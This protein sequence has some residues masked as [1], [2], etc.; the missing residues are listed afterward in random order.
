MRRQCA[1]IGKYYIY[2]LL[3]FAY[4][5][6]ERLNVTEIEIIRLYPHEHMTVSQIADKLDIDLSWAS[7][8][9]SHLEEIGFLTTMKKSKELYV[10]LTGSSLG[11]TLSILLVEEP[12]MN[13]NTLLGGSSLQI[14]P[15]LLSPGYSTREIVERTGLSSRTIQNRIKKWRGMGVVILKKPHYELSQRHPLVIDLMEE[16]AK[17]RNLCHLRD[18]YPKATIVWQDRDDYII[19]TEKE[20]TDKNYIM[21]GPTKV[22]QYGYDIVSRNYYYC[23]SPGII[24]ISEAEALVQT[25]KFDLINP[26]PV[27]YIIQAIENNRVTKDEIRNYAKKYKI[28]ERVEEA[29]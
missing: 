2:H 10:G 3:I 6:K 22:A 28:Q 24:S 29:L 27:E 16:Y 23:Y 7:K 20:L 21:A 25:V 8:C 15:L 13:V 19:S 14:L 4:M 9:I 11:S 17:H 12:A 26:R 5:Y 1:I 18:S